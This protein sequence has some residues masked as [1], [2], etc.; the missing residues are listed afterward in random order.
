MYC[1]LDQSWFP[2]IGYHGQVMSCHGSP[3]GPTNGRLQKLERSDNEFWRALVLINVF[4]CSFETDISLILNTIKVKIISQCNNVFR[5]INSAGSSHTSSNIFL[6]RACRTERSYSVSPNSPLPELDLCWLELANHPNH[7]ERA[8][9]T[10]YLMDNSLF[11]E[12]HLNQAL[13]RLISGQARKCL[14]D[15]AGPCISAMI[16]SK[17]IF[18]NYFGV[19]QLQNYQLYN[20]FNDTNL[21]ILTKRVFKFKFGNFVRTTICYDGET[22][23]ITSI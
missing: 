6:I 12:H 10:G 21:V 17:S 15:P 1:L 19:S 2:R 11:Y 7:Q 20:H 22:P 5:I 9:W 4:E 13:V 3:D 14:A 16:F 18:L 8:K 23:S